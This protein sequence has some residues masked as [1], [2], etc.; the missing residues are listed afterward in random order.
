MGTYEGLRMI[1][2]VGFPPPASK[3]YFHWAK[4]MEKLGDKYIVSDDLDSNIVRDADCYYQ[5]N[6]LKPKFLHGG[7]ADWHGK[8][9]L[10][11]QEAGK[12]YI[13]SESEPFRE[14]LGWLRFGWNSY[15]WC[16]ANWNNENV[17]PE[18]W[19]RFENLTGIKFTDWHSPGKNI[20]IM[21]QK[22]GDSSLVNIYKAGYASVYD[23]IADQCRVIRRFTDRPIVIRPHPRN[24]DR[25][26]KIVTRLLAEL[27]MKD[28]SMSPNLT[29]GG[30]QGGEGL[31]KDLQEAYCV[32]TYNSLSGVEA[33]VRGIPV[34]ALDGGSM[35][36]P[37]AHTELSQIE[38]LNYDIDLQEWKNKIAYAMWNKQDVQTGECWAHLKEVYFKD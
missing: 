3:P 19:N 10:H 12:P 8:Y 25:G 17:G 26:A 29:R 36:W 30:S 28:V 37:V 13:V 16:D 11:I 21:G 31:D 18:R 22:E 23:Y 32:V 33:V 14:C 38:N 7:R 15:R 27:D 9:L 1:K 24:L 5:T 4:G 35:A 20:L 2:M 34:F 6:E